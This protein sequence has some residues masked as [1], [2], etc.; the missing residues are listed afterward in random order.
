MGWQPFILPKSNT[1][2]VSPRYKDAYAWQRMLR[3]WEEKRDL[4][5]KHYHQRSNVESTFSMMKRKF[6]PYVRSKSNQAQFNEMLAKVVCHNASVLCTAM[7][8]LDVNIN[9]EEVG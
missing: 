5:L 2:I 8:E 3:F 6:L 7:F 4:F 9:F 1:V